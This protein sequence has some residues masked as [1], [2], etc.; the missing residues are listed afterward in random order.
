MFTRLGR[1]GRGRLWRYAGRSQTACAENSTDGTDARQQWRRWKIVDNN[2]AK[3][4]PN[5]KLPSELTNK[6]RKQ[7]GASRAAGKKL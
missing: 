6:E 5:V 4:S 2:N 7:I 1:L 3:K